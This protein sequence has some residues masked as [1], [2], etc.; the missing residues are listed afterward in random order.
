MRIFW[1][2]RIGPEAFS[3]YRAPYNTRTNN[4]VESHNATL[5]RAVKEEVHPP[6]WDL[7]GEFLFV[8]PKLSL[9]LRSP[10]LSMCN[11]SSFFQKR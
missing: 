8:A 4:A 11:L 3:V 6:I 9:V 7:I 1:L 5:L 10:I 2:E